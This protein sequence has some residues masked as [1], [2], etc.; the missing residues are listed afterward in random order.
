MI[1]PSCSPSHRPFA[2]LLVWRQ[3]G[4]VEE[5]E[6]EHVQLVDERVDVVT[7]ILLCVT[8][9]RTSAFLSPFRSLFLP[10]VAFEVFLELLVLLLAFYIGVT[11]WRRAPLASAS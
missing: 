10:L 9:L 2:V 4:D 7:T 1:M 6:H 5:K 8:S 3:L 11:S